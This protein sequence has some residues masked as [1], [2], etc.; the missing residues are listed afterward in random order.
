MD[1]FYADRSGPSGKQGS[2]GGMFFWDVGS[3][4]ISFCL[5]PIRSFIILILALERVKGLKKPFKSTILSVEGRRIQENYNEENAKEVPYLH[6]FFY[7][8]LF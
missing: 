8:N 4:R 6:W 7:V 1:L 3:S 2:G 5:D